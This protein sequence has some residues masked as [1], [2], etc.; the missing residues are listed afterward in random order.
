LDNIYSAPNADLSAAPAEGDATYT[1]TLFAL[2]GRI[3]RLR[4]IAYPM[5]A[6][7]VFMAAM[8]VVGAITVALPM[9]GMVLMV[10]LYIPMIAVGFI[11]TIRRLNDLNH[12]GWFCL[13]GLVPF[14]NLIFYL[15]LWFAPGTAG[16]NDYGLPPGPNTFWVKV[17]ALV[18]PIIAII[19]IL[20]AIAIPAYQGYVMKAKAAQSE[21]Q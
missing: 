1:P 12:S 15:Y 10:V 3:G 4:G 11:Y 19:G 8:M 20:A 7:L 18:L 9:L 6:M 13:L 17:G 16:P 2:S 21:Q 5:G 14:L